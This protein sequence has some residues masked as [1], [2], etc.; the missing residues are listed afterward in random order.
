MEAADAVY[1]QRAMEF[2]LKQRKNK[3]TLM[4][5]R[6]YRRMSMS[7]MKFYSRMHETIG[8]IDN[9]RLFSRNIKGKKTK[10]HGRSICS[11]EN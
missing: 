8:E 2:K 3:L 11:K 7:D 1:I 6:S 5:I 10:E 4:F 9:H